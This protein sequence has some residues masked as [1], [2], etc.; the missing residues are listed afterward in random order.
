MLTPE[1]GDKWNASFAAVF[2]AAR[3]GVRLL[4][5]LRGGASFTKTRRVLLA[6]ASRS[7]ASK[8]SR[9]TATIAKD[10]FAFSAY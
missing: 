7:K 5:L 6:A 1:D 3:F 9:A 2:Y 10:F 8:T 4:L